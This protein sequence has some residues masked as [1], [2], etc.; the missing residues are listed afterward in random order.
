MQLYI[1]AL[2][3]EETQEL[4]GVSIHKIWVMPISLH[5]SLY[6]KNMS[7]DIVNLT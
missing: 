4:I 2:L 1:T 6:H 5:V 3:E 7:S